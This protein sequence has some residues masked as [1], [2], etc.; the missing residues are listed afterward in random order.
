MKL[1]RLFWF[2]SFTVLFIG[3]SF[4]SPLKADA[5]TISS[6]L[7]LTEDTGG[8]AFFPELAPTAEVEQ[9]IFDDLKIRDNRIGH[10]SSFAANDTAVDYIFSATMV[11]DYSSDVAGYRIVFARA[12]E[13]LSLLDDVIQI[14]IRVANGSDIAQLE[15]ST[16]PIHAKE[17]AAFGI[18]DSYVYGYNYDINGAYV[19]TIYRNPG[20]EENGYVSLFSNY[21]TKPWINYGNR[22]IYTNAENAGNT[23]PW[24][25]LESYESG[26]DYSG[27][28]FSDIIE[29]LQMLFN[30]LIIVVNR[31][32]N[33]ITEGYAIWETSMNSLND[34]TGAASAA[35]G[36]VIVDKITEV[37]DAISAT[38]DNFWNSLL[39]ILGGIVTELLDGFLA[40]IFPS[41]EQIAT[42][43]DKFDGM[44]AKQFG[45]IYMLMEVLMTQLNPMVL[46]FGEVTT[47]NMGTLFGS[48]LVLDLTALETNFPTVWLVLVSGTRLMIWSNVLSFFFRR[49]VSI[50]NGATNGAYD[51]V[52]YVFMDDF[53]GI[54]G[55]HSQSFDRRYENHL[56]NAARALRPYDFGKHRTRKGG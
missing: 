53:K 41:Q 4:F 7:V 28:F 6:G 8:S 49:V 9:L 27:G 5:A 26:P 50:V 25:L 18:E 35:L 3:Q 1:K 34:V 19:S 51:D 44:M 56:G 48:P 2:F 20:I 45:V 39:D 37:V 40:M 54:A 11:N 16:A 13:Q 17:N 12:I 30:E 24:N 32:A 10:L 29:F 47:I 55:P 43:Q 38:W 36:R 22:I 31:I 52:G 21:A 42:L 15:A 46:E 33:G 23:S 14:S